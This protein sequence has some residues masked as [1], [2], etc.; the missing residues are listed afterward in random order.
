MNNPPQKWRNLPKS[1]HLYTQTHEADRTYQVQTC[2]WGSRCSHWTPLTVQKK[3]LIQLQ[4]KICAK[5]TWSDH[6]S[7]VPHWAKNQCKL[8]LSSALLVLQCTEGEENT[9]WALQT[10]LVS[11]C[12]DGGS[13]FDSSCLFNMANNFPTRYLENKR[14]NYGMFT[15]ATAAR[16]VA[17]RLL[18]ACP[19]PECQSGRFML[20]PTQPPFLQI[21]GTDAMMLQK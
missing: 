12:W 16:G 3:T 10:C 19:S 5:N 7:E 9:P 17:G 13:V 11:S 8:K 18:P 14:C 21:E 1:Y 6:H 20:S 15:C 2:S 4:C